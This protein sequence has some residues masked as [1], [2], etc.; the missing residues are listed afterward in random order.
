VTTTIEQ[1]QKIV[2]D[3]TRTAEERKQAAEHILKLQGEDGA[4]VIRDSDPE[5]VQ[6]MLAWNG[7]CIPDIPSFR[8]A[9]TILDLYGYDVT[10]KQGAKKMLARL[11]KEKELQAIISNDSLPMDE[12]IDVVQKW[13]DLQPR[14]EAWQYV[15]DLN[16]IEHL[17]PH[18]DLD[19]LKE[20]STFVCDSRLTQRPNDDWR[21]YLAETW[22]L[23]E[24]FH[25]LR[26]KHPK[27]YAPPM[28]NL[29]SLSGVS[30]QLTGN[31]Q[32][33]DPVL[34][35]RRAFARDLQNGQ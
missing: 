20:L 9:D 28:L 27:R 30:Y 3:E 35:Q 14:P 29:E 16:L 15:S 34:R 5:L 7:P 31:I 13:R 4:D 22:K 25:E 1:L 26:G 24:E 6:L 23:I 17:T 12:R 18:P 8:I 32:V 33:D 10:T 19:R 21:T 11:R 2:G